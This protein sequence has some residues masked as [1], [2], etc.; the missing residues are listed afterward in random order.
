[1]SENESI[2]YDPYEIQQREIEKML[3]AEALS[4]ADLAKKPEAVQLLLR[5]Q[6]IQLYEL[7]AYKAELAEMQRTSARLREEREELRIELAGFKERHNASLIEIPISIVSGFAIN[8]LTSNLGSPQ[9]WLLLL[10]TLTLLAFLRR[11]QIGS[12]IQHTSTRR[13]A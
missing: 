9:G 11:S 3:G 1:M 13:E 2:T 4:I 8:M 10:L 5:Q 7:R 6:S 12:L